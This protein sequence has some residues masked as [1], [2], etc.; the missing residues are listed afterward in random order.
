MVRGEL[1]LTEVVVFV[2]R[3]KVAQFAL[4]HAHFRVVVEHVTSQHTR[5][6]KRLSA[7]VAHQRQV[8]LLVLV[9]PA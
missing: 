6:A 2:V 9:L 5:V 7:E 3:F 8:T 1:L 4:V